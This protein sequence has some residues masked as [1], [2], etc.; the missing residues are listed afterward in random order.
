MTR[1]VW[2]LCA[3]LVAATPAAAQQAGTA[4]QPAPAA[5]DAERPPEAPMAVRQGDTDRL[6]SP[7]PPAI[8]PPPPPGPGSQTVQVGDDGPPP[9]NGSPRFLFRDVTDRAT[10]RVKTLSERAAA[11]ES[12][13]QSLDRGGPR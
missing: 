2:L 9:E 12:L 8:A 7:P 6:A 4:M 5:I 3:T 1:V 13:R 10:P 11:V